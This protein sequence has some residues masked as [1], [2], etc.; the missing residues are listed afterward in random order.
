M[1]LGVVDLAAVV[2]D[3]VEGGGDVSVGHP[4]YVVEHDNSVCARAR[5]C[6]QASLGQNAVKKKSNHARIDHAL[7][8]FFSQ[9][10]SF[11][12][13]GLPKLAAE[14]SLRSCAFVA[15][16]DAILFHPIKR[17]ACI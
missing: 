17:L 5:T 11:K 7:I 9:R 3:S 1:P 8:L 16:N 14:I 4:V 13:S 2:L 15:V 12:H 10:R 6:E